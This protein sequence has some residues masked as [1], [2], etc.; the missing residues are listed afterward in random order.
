VIHEDIEFKSQFFEW[1]LQL[2]TALTNCVLGILLAILNMF[3]ILLMFEFKAFV[4]VCERCCVCL[5][6]CWLEHFSVA[7][8][9]CWLA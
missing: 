7:Y 3:G 1:P 5:V 8:C 4:L 6:G 9:K 2:I